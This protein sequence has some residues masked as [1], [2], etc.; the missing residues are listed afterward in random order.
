[1]TIVFTYTKGYFTPCGDVLYKKAG[2]PKVSRLIF[3]LLN[4]L[5]EVERQNNHIAVTAVYAVCVF[6]QSGV[7]KVTPIFINDV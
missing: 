1:M 3:I 7:D 2:F 5:L 4:V 6:Q